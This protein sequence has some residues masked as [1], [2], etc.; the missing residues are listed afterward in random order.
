[1]LV[2]AL[3]FFIFSGVGTVAWAEMKHVIIGMNGREPVVL[4]VEFANDKNG[5]EKISKTI[6]S[7]IMKRAKDG[8][9]YSQMYLGRGFEMEKMDSQAVEW[10]GKSANQG[11]K[12]AQYKMGMMYY[13]GR[14][15]KKDL[16]QAVAWLHKAGDGE[17]GE[18][19]AQYLLYGM[20]GNG[21][22]VAKD[23][24]QA[25]AWL[26]KAAEHGNP[27]AQYYLGSRY[28]R[29]DGVERD[30]RKTMDWWQKSAQSENEMAWE[31]LSWMYWNS[32][33]GIERNVAEHKKWHGMYCQSKNRTWKEYAGCKTV[34]TIRWVREIFE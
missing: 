21:E 23:E 4:D 8:D 11:N 2:R 30:C 29:G 33:C 16:L 15:I 17:D 13:Y 6:F 1:M 26:K 9:A 22:G 5:L 7:E 34:G 31:G 12:F 18:N 32:G 3:A 19:E 28:L 27:E 14:G 10:Y 24:R 20:Y 25:M